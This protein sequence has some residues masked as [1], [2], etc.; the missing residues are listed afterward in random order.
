MLTGDA[1]QEHE[2]TK[3]HS[4][5]LHAAT[6]A[7]GGEDNVRD[8]RLAYFRARP[9]S[10]GGYDLEHMVSDPVDALTEL[11]EVKPPKDYITGRRR[12][13]RMWGPNRQYTFARTSFVQIVVRSPLDP[14]SKPIG[15]VL[16]DS[17]KRSTFKGAGPR[18][19]ALCL[20][21]WLAAGELAAR[22]ELRIPAGSLVSGA[23]E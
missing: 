9:A 1:H 3:F 20:A 8:V 13:R 15:V 2:L 16:G 4:S 22:A 21:R 14:Q 5:L 12:F 17:P 11:D 6:R 23:R 19:G 7:W 18:A 10:G